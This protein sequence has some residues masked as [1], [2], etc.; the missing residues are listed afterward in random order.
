MS[1]L[2]EVIAK[3]RP[4]IKDNSIYQYE[5]SLLKLKKLFNADDYAFLQN[6]MDVEEMLKDLHFTSVRNYYNAIIV[7]L[8]AI[9]SE[10]EYDEEIKEYSDMR[11]ELNKQYEED[12]ASGKISK[13]QEANFVDISEVEK[14]ISQMKSDI[15][16]GNLVTKKK[17]TTKDISLLRSYV[18]FSMLVR[19]PTRNDASD[20]IFITRHTYNKLS[21]EDK[22]KNNFVVIKRGGMDFIYNQYKTSKKYKENVISVPKDLERIMRMYI[23]L[24]NFKPN[25]NIFPMSRN[26]ISQL[27]LKQSQKYMGKRISS[28]M[29]RKIYLSSKY[30]DVLQEMKE[31]AKMMG[32]DI[33]TAQKVYIKTGQGEPV[34][35]DD[36]EPVE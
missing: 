15:K 2:K 32:H 1:E 17:L 6:P 20:M 3:A 8:M 5:R 25:D 24:M 11:D 22:E 26:A 29:I 10:K 27:L 33:A 31:D 30:G 16:S 9:N 36:E 23:K 35:D 21:D 4:N 14:M 12:N 19:I 13:K 7:Y 18:L 34:D 28:T